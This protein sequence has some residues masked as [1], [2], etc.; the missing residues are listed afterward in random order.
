MR[1]PIARVLAVV[2]AAA[3]SAST[4]GVTRPTP[5]AAQSAPGSASGESS[6]L[7]LGIRSLE[8]DDDF[9]RNLT[10]AL[11]HAANQIDGWTVS[12]REV[13]LAQMALAH[14]C[15][16]PDAVCLANI[17]EALEADLVVYGDVRRT[18]ARDRFDF[19][20]NLHVFNR[21]LQQIE[22][23]VAETVPG[24]RRDIDD[25]RE[26]ARRYVAALSGAPRAGTLSVSV[27]VPGAEIFVDGVS[28][29]SADSEGHLV[30]SDVAAGT[31][32]VRVVADG[33]Q[34]FR[35]SVTVEA[36]GE[37]TFEAELASTGAGGGVDP[38][39]VAG[40]GVLAVG[41]A[42]A[43]LWIYAM[44][45]IQFD[46][47]A[48]ADNSPII[49]QRWGSARAQY[50]G[51]TDFCEAHR[52]IYPTE[53]EAPRELGYINDLCDRYDTW[54][55]LQFVFLGVAALA[56]GVGTYL[57]VEGL[58]GDAEDPEAVSLRV[59]PSFGPDRGAIAVQ[60]TF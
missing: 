21:A 27:N 40:L 56:G 5:A 37:A 10:G 43:A 35:S 31:R 22:H 38:L 45:T 14:G 55:P 19:S 3:V 48:N 60:G 51:A 47:G 2:A 7:V 53:A 39:L 50:P 23:S 8:G 12:D 41:A 32:N 28:T 54:F 52:D 25:L 9:T 59:V 15:P 24:V 36:Y 11:R 42:A 29:G 30:V 34:S 44:A 26:P 33:H 16:D 58:S 1:I 13:T 46:I 6:V 17:A 18:S 4:L 49:P 20:L 57:L